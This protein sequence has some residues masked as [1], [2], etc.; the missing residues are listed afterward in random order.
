MARQKLLVSFTD[1]PQTDALELTGEV[2]F[3]N[4]VLDAQVRRPP[5]TCPPSPAAWL[6]QLV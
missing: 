4:L 5:P 6:G 2:E 1:N 3:P